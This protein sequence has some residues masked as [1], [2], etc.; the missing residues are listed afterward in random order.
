MKDDSG[1]YAVFTEQGSS[2]SQMTAA[3]VLDVICQITW[4]RRRR[5]ISLHPSQDG[6]RSE[7][8]IIS[9]I[10]MS[11]CLDSTTTTQVSE[12]LEN[13]QDLVVPLETTNL[14]GHPLASGLVRRFQRRLLS[15]TNGPAR[16]FLDRAHGCH[17]DGGQQ[18]SARH[19]PQQFRRRAHSST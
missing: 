15:Q 18:G 16:A 3:K 7:I 2:V 8:I 5:S 13:I 14:C 4:M 1:S 6:G 9:G 11:R 17:S 10:G 12:S 19:L